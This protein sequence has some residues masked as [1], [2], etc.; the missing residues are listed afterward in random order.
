E[1]PEAVSAAVIPVA[2]AIALAGRRHVGKTGGL[3]Y[4]LAFDIVLAGRLVLD[5]HAEIALHGLVLRAA[6]LD[7][8]FVAGAGSILGGRIGDVGA[9]GADLL[10]V[11]VAAAL[12]HVDQQLVP[13]VVKLGGERLDGSSLPRE[14]GGGG[15]ER[16]GGA[17]EHGVVHLARVVGRGRATGIGARLPRL[18]GAVGG[19]AN[20]S[21]TRIGVGPLFRPV[22]LGFL[23]RA[24]QASQIHGLDRFVVALHVLDLLRQV[25]LQFDPVSRVFA[26]GF[27]FVGGAPARLALVAQKVCGL[28]AIRAA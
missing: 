19:G 5:G 1:D 4:A 22:G 10:L 20:G 25:L 15:F 8:V 2:V 6:D 11:L 17:E 13:G 21:E 24:G 28:L 12:L 14:I 18:V 3:R 27:D 16:V 23:H 9:N 26:D 7:P